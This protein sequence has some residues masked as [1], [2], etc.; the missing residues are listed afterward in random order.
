TVAEA[1]SMNTPVVGYDHGGVGEILAEQFPQGAVPVGDVPAAAARL[2][3]ILN[4]PDSPVIRPAQ[5]T[6]EQMVNATL[7]VYRNAVTQRKHE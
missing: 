2:A 4:G 3:M 6:R 1:L 7:N 5:W